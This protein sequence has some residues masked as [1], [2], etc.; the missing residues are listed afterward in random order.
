MSDA[1]RKDLNHFTQPLHIG[2]HSHLSGMLVFMLSRMV[3]AQ[4]AASKTTAEAGPREHM[5]SADRLTVQQK[6]CKQG[7]AQLTQQK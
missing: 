5:Q 1:W 4:A 3:K 6:R 7:L 2:Q